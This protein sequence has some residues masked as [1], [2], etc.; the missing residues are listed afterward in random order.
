METEVGKYLDGYIWKSAFGFCKFS[1][2][3][4]D[5]LD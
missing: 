2:L 3:A 1:K 5:N 4:M